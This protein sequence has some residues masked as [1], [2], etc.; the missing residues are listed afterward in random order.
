MAALNKS[1]STGSVLMIRPVQSM[2]FDGVAGV[3]LESMIEMG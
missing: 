1:I 3:G 2:P